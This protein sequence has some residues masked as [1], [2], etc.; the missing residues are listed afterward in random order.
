MTNRVLKG[1]ALVLVVAA[2][3]ALGRYGRGP[4]EPA[5]TTMP[6]I[7]P[8]PFDQPASTAPTPTTP[9]AAPEESRGCVGPG[10]TREQVLEVMG[11]PDTIVGGWWRYGQ[12]Q[13]HLGSGT[14]Q[15]FINGG[16]VPL[17]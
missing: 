13:F 12:T 17:C 6:P 5:P 7:S 9:T 10:S 2:A 16:G 8:P 14:V 11:E 4:A 3:F 1:L 15:D